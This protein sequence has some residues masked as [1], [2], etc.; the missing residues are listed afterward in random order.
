M[1]FLSFSK[2]QDA[3]I[4]FQLCLWTPLNNLCLINNRFL[5]KTMIIDVL[6]QL[7]I[8]TGVKQVRED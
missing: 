1:L 4:T 8:I 5:S 2:L 6:C 7:K 3:Y